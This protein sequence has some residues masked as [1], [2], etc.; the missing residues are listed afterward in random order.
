MFYNDRNLKKKILFSNKT[1]Y[2]P[3]TLYRES[4]ISTPSQQLTNNNG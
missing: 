1:Q 3:E 2:E 4:L